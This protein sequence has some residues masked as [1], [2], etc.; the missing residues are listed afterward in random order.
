MGNCGAR[1]IPYVSHRISI[2]MPNQDDQKDQDSPSSDRPYTELPS[3]VFLEINNNDNLEDGSGKESA[4]ASVLS[5]EIVLQIADEAVS[6]VES[7]KMT[8]SISR[9]R[10]GGGESLNSPPVKNDS[11]KTSNG[12]CK[13][14]AP[15]VECSYYFRGLIDR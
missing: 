3:H 11:I 14:V 6:R 9:K 1:A 15:I 13:K 4:P 7:S 12:A 10:N 5:N 2:S 8:P